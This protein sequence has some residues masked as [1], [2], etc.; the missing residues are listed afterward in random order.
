[1]HAQLPQVVTLQLPPE[2]QI[3][4]FLQNL[5][6]FDKVAVTQEDARRTRLYRENLARQ[7]S[8]NSAGDIADFIAS[9]QLQV[10]IGVPDE[11]EWARV[12]QLTQRTNQFNFTTRR[13]NESEMRALA[14][15]GAVVERVRVRDRFGDYGLVGVM[16]SDTRDSTLLIDTL[17]VSCRVLGRGV[18]HTMLRHLGELARE[19]GLSCVELPCT[20]SARNE[21][22]QAFA[23]SVAAPY[24]LAEGGQLRY[25][26]PVQA[27]C[28]I[29]HQ[30]GQDPRAVVEARKAEDAKAT[31]TDPSLDAGTGRA[32][33]YAKLATVLTSGAGVLEAL[34]SHQRRTRPLRER[35]VQAAS[36]TERQLLTLWQEL[37]NIEDLGVEDNYFALG[38][39]SLL[40]AR[41]FAEIARR[42]GVRLRLT[43]IVAAPT[44][45]SLARA[46]Q[47]EQV[48]QAGDAA[49]LLIELKAGGPMRLFLVHD[50][51]G[52]TLLYRNLAQRLPSALSVYGIE[53]RRLPGV[54]LA[55]G[56]IAEMARDYIVHVRRLQ[57][58]GPYRL[59]G[60]C[61]GAVIA[62][63]MARQ[64]QAAGEQ[65]A[66]VALMDAARPHAARR[67][68]RISRERAQ[69][70][71]QMLASLR[72][73]QGGSLARLGRALLGTTRKGM[74]L[75][76]WTLQSRLQRL[77]VR[78][79]FA[80]LRRLLAQ[81]QPWPARTRPLSV[82]EIYDSAESE[83]LP[84]PLVDAG[85]VLLRAS[86]GLGE[87]NDIP[88]QS[89]YADETLGWRGL[90][91]DLEVL[92]AEG[93][94]SS[95]L[96][97]PQVISLADALAER[98]LP[99]LERDPVQVVAS[100][101]AR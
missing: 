91:S 101:G 66:L 34:R 38:G 99:R 20:R 86:Q 15:K 19:G 73:T 85:V 13:R 44:L 63:E 49:S 88:Y 47:S 24:R 3:A 57:P 76:R 10:D 83:Y 54:P 42:F 32:R 51:D 41:M 14:G 70:F 93:G 11:Q 27:A 77:S 79:R 28:E 35:A 65:V 96:Q 31:R 84:Q 80:M 40:A 43:T 37:L 12:A 97:E 67:P 56:S 68:G 17:L 87:P 74:G 29:R 36:P 26:I 52:E 8:E 1:M 22:A 53:P 18:E 5:W 81:H 45:R 94:H 58:A 9:L 4:E 62:Y 78:R 64:L 33:R 46:L 16:I 39:T 55:A 60:L 2:P 95:M 7:A 90:V 98:M 50:G 100:S 92:D 71:E 6:V 21:P 25:R 82:R 69:R 23:D 89:I 48:T 61:A 72:E 59:G 75:V 30:P